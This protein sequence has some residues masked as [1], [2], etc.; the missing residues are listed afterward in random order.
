ML[1]LSYICFY[2]NIPSDVNQISIFCGVRG[3]GR[4]LSPCCGKSM[5]DIGTRNRKSKE[6]S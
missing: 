2:Y 1:F 4:I 5:S 6:S 3:A